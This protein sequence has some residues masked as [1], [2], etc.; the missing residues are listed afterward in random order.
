MNR[1]RQCGAKL[2]GGGHI[3][4]TGRQLCGPCDDELVGAVVAT[5]TGSPATGIALAGND[6]R[7]SAGVLAWI[8]KALRRE[9]A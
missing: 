1:C 6:D 4:P 9:R 5:G 3:S 8:R 7:V 2:Q